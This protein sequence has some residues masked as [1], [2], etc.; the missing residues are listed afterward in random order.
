M[1]PQ[2]ATFVVRARDADAVTLCLFDGG[3]EERLRMTGTGE[4]HVISVP[5]IRPGQAYGYRATGSWAPKAGHCFDDAKL[6]TDPYAL[7]LD[8]RYQFDPRL[9]VRGEDTAA[10]VPK[11][12]V[13]AL[14]PPVP[15]APPRFSPCGLIY[16]LNVRAFT[17]DHP[18]VPQGQRG[19]VASL[20]HPA[21]IAHL[22]KLRVAAIELM[23]ITA[24]IDERHLPPLGL[25]NAWGYNPVTLMAPD[26]GL[27]PGGIGELRDTVAALHAEGIGVI[28]DMVFN[29]TGESDALGPTLSMRGL[30]G[31]YY[32][33]EDDGT[34]INDTG[35]GNTLDFSQ[36]IARELTLDTL[37]HFVTQAGIDGFRFDLAPVMARGPGFDPHAPIFAA[38]AGDPVL[39]DRILIAEPWD[40]GP[41]GYQLGHFPMT[42]LEWNDRYRDDVRRFWRGDPHM[43]GALATRMTGSDDIFVGPRSRGVSFLAAHD[44]FTLADMLAYEDR[45]NEANGENNRDG[46]GEN[47]SW[48]N[49]AE[50]P[51]ADEKVLARRAADARALL[52]TLFATRGAIMLTAGDEFGRTQRGNNNAYAQDNAITWLDWAGRDRAL[53]DYVA[54]LADFR[55]AHPA[56]SDPDFLDHADWRGLDGRPMTPASWEAADTAGFELRPPGVHGLVVRVDRQARQCTLAAFPHSGPAGAD[57]AVQDNT[58]SGPDRLP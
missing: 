36:P 27:C 20:A 26:P 50:G 42:W 33:R 43:A 40:I 1:S 55:A 38:I 23:P 15:H 45:H 7:A 6:L 2:G 5:G 28:L 29:H 16:E 46:H 32:A 17:H 10:L 3:R 9:C 4:W 8:R 49:G 12:L 37:R 11:A 30:D 51:S 48:N 18:D 22:K 41:S 44:G 14:S 53:E 54:G 47:F 35:T 39:K 13:T 19:T 58:L 52:A 21:I 31:R 24:W 25:T 34:L 56:L 57:I